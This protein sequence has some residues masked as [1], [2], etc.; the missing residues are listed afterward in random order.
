MIYKHGITVPGTWYMLAILDALAEDVGV[1]D[2][3]LDR[4]A[5]TPDNIAGV[6]ILTS[7]LEFRKIFGRPLNSYGVTP[8]A[9]FREIG[10]AIP[11]E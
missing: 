6:G 3:W 7:V 10:T 8:L 2:E 11:L 1:G 5:G 4:A 9:I